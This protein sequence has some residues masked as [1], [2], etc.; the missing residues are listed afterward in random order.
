M[1][2]DLP[3]NFSILR[4]ELLTSMLSMGVEVMTCNGIY[5]DGVKGRAKISVPH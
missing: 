1:V 5:D 2:P 4:K 3:F